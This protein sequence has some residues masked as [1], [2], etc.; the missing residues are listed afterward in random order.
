MDFSYLDDWTEEEAGAT[1]EEVG[2][3]YRHVWVLAETEGGALLPATFEAMGQA[4]DLA[5]QI[6]VYLYGILLGHQVKPLGQE[7]AAYGADKVLV[8]DDAL[9]AEYQPGLYTQ[10]VADLVDRYHPEIML[11]PATPLGNDLAPR[12]AQRL[13]T[14]LISHCIELGIEFTERLLLGTTPVFGGEMHHT[15]TCPEARPQIATLQPGSFRMPYQDAYRSAEVQL[16]DVN[17]ADLSGR[18]DWIDLAATVDPPAM[19]LSKARVVVAGG[20]GMGD[21][22]GF[23]LV[24]QLANALGGVVAGSRGA[25]DEGWITEEQIVGVGGEFVA[26]DLYVACGIS[27]DIY[28]SFGLRNAKFVV[29][30]NPDEEA[31]INKLANMAIVG[32]ARPIISAWLDALAS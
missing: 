23:A 5:D 28:H 3:G 22:E 21:A 30:I 17:L 13:D 4:R 19:P 8:V 27:G 26:P 16:V 6:G 7:L 31:P 29:A 9:L 12:L 18:L 25:F 14:G 20:R 11:L 1:I 15:F 32:D 2:E 10:A 24:E